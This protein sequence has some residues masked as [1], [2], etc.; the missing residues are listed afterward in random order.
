MSGAGVRCGH[1]IGPARRY[2][3]ATAGLRHFVIGVRC[4]AH[5]PDALK[6]LT[7]ARQTT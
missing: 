4:P 5:T 7:T 3:H 2:C 1:W 6:Q